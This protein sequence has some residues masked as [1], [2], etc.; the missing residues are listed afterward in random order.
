MNK[1]CEKLKGF[2][3]LILRLGLAAVFIYHGYGKIF[4]DGAGFGASWNP[5]GMPAWMQV[6]VS[7][8][9]FLAGLGFLT[10]VMTC[11]ASLGIIFIMAGAIIAVHG[12]NGFSL[13]N[14]GFEYNY[15][16]IMMCLALI[17]TGP[18]K[19]ALPFCGWKCPLEKDKQK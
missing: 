1:C 5:H 10:G 8:G 12:K 16:L 11:G 7:W 17:I 13:M 19:F 18:G 2:E 9:E 4:A 15:V 6:L 3:G 14:K